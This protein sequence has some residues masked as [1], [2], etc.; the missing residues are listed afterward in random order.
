MENRIMA[1]I[2]QA[3]AMIKAKVDA[4]ELTDAQVAALHKKLDIGFDEHFLY[5][6]VKSLAQL[7]GKLTHDEAVTVYA[8]LGGD[9]S[10]FNGQGIGVKVVLTK[11]FKELMSWKLGR[12]AG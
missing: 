1:S 2:N 8:Y 3:A 12:R 9:A 10:V 4:G 6:E 7:H 11:V 5:Q